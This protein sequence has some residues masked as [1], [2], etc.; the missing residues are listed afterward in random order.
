[1]CAHLKELDRSWSAVLCGWFGAVHLCQCGVAWRA[2]LHG[3][4]HYFGANSVFRV[5]ILCG[6][7][8]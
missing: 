6:L 5:A 3:G 1:M 7:A 2:A 8:G 4:M